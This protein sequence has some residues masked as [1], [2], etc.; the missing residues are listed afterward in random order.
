MF[1]LL[2]VAR[3]LDDLAPEALDLVGGHLAELL[4]D[5]VAGFQLLAVDQERARPRERIAVLVVVPEERPAD[6][7]QPLSFRLRCS[8]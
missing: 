6:R 3:A 5:R 7:A 8:R 4:V 2:R 1:R